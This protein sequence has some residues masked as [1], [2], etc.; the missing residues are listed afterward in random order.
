[1]RA[2]FRQPRPARQD[3]HLAALL[4]AYT[5]AGVPD[6]EDLGR[7]PGLGP[8]FA[9]VRAARA[10]FLADAFLETA[11]DAAFA[12]AL[13]H[14]Y[15]AC[16][17]PPLHREVPARRAGIV[18]HAVGHL[19]RC[20]DALPVKLERCLAA[21]GPYHVAGLGPAF[22]SALAQALDPVRHPAW[23]PAVETGLRRLGLASWRTSDTPAAVYGALL[24]AYDRLRGLAPGLTALHL[25]H[26][27]V[28]VGGMPG[29]TL[30][31]GPDAAGRLHPIA[32]GLDLAALVR[33]ERAVVP[34]RRRLKER[35]RA[36][37]EARARLEAALAVQDG[38]EIGAALAAA[39]PASARRAPVDWK[40]CA[41][42]LTLW[43]GRLWEA[44]DP[45]EVL[46]AF[47]QADPVPGAGLWLPP[48]V[49]HLRDPRR[50]DPWDEAARQGHAVL[51]DSADRGDPPAERYLLFNAAV[52]WLREH[53]RLHPLEAPAVLAAV[54]A[55]RPAAEPVEDGRFGGFCPDTFRFLDELA[56]NNNRAWMDKQRDRYRFAVREPLVE[57]CRALAERYVGPVLCGSHGWDLETRAKSGRALTSICKNDYGRSVPYNAAL[58][59]TFYRKDRGGKR[60]DVQFFVRLD[61]RGLQYGLRLGRAAREA[62]RLFRR[63]VQEHAELL[64]RALRATGA[65]AECRFGTVEDGAP[66]TALTGPG[67]LRAWAAGKELFAARQV[68]AD[69]PLLAGDDLVGEVLL[70]FDRLLPA[71]ACAVLADPRPLLERRAGG[72]PGSAF[73]ADD[74][75]RE[76]YLGDDWLRRAR[77]LL[78]LKRQLI[79]QGVP[80]TGKT[81]VARCLAR[82]LT[83]SR[84]D[85]VRLV[86]FHPAYSYE[87]FV[88]GIKVKSVEVDG[89]HDV[90]Y[91]VE[92]GLLCAFAA[93]AARR[94]AEPFVLV[95][96]EINRGNLP[97]VFGELLY[98][99]EYR[100]QAV[101]LPYSKRGF[102]LP[103]NLYLLGTMNAADR[104]VALV[105]Q[106]LRRRFSFLEMPPD[107]G[108]LAGWLSAHPP[109]AGEEFA[110]GVVRLFERLNA[111]LRSDLG[112]QF[113]VG[114]SYFMVPDLDEDRLRT[115]WRHQVRPLLE[116]YF[117]GQP[118]RAA[119]YELEALLPNGR[120]GK[121]RRRPRGAEVG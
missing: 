31:P 110:A 105:D 54:G 71:Y 38:S 11:G 33:Q 39:D 16:V 82:L 21:D 120:G 34:L 112:P 19:L 104:S 51:D 17:R 98:L 84:D 27:L 62:G 106:A 92:D 72:R 89:R 95:I 75:R 85:A 57:L 73:G 86:Q 36:L 87:E 10:D 56:H 78:D 15:E 65:A 14:F 47:W 20:P 111:R 121:E 69:S 30:H 24:R 119:G 117:T 4:R 49:L 93:E 90:T 103:A 1:M 66:A 80:G 113:Q 74:F 70:T 60:D 100:D 32:A 77:E 101:G 109:A 26:F 114:H 41:E 61:A 99:L 108:V 29:R 23:V 18:R 118:Q 25:D 22:W 91:P 2:R 9:A 7:L 88:E 81:H 12:A 58:W 43:V 116:E 53:H 46:R 13:A 35:G 83:G 107:A 55:R 48:A 8:R 45:A 37:H 94:P 63:N 64:A 102:R 44:D 79:L 68:P 28:L 115:V 3:A 67:D 50:F 5:D 76:T 97:R 42:D 59:L 96:D 52:A 6:L 40:G